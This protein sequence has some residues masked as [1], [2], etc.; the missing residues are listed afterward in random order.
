M[1]ERE[2][3]RERKRGKE[4]K[5]EREEEEVRGRKKEKESACVTR[6]FVDILNLHALVCCVW[7]VCVLCV[8]A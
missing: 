5:S 6:A 8:C 1:R 7:S 4:G 2:R 3:E